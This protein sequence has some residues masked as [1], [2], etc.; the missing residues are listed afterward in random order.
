MVGRLSEN[1]SRHN[2]GEVVD[3]GQGKGNFPSGNVGS[4]N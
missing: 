2:S 3:R 1:S 4:F